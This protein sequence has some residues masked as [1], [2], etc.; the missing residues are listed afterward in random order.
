MGSLGLEFGPIISL[1]PLLPP[2][3]SDSTVTAEWV[4][5][6]TAMAGGA[7]RLDRP[8]QSRLAVVY[9]LTLSI[10]V[11]LSSSLVP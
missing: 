11:Q 5:L 2:W 10:G 9:A 4:I 8:E 3:Q 6:P 1:E 7:M